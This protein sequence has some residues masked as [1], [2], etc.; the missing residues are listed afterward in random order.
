MIV[1]DNPQI[2]SADDNES[3][4]QIRIE[5]LVHLSRELAERVSLLENVGGC[6]EIKNGAVQEAE[7]CSAIVPKNRRISLGDVE[8]SP[9]LVAPRSPYEREE[10]A[11]IIAVVE[12]GPANNMFDR[13]LAIEQQLDEEERLSFENVVDVRPNCLPESTFSLLI[14]EDPCSISFAFGVLTVGLSI[15][16]LGL[17]LASSVSVDKNPLSIPTDVDRIVTVS[18]FTG[19]LVGC[20][21]ED[22][23]PQGLQLIANGARHVLLLNGKKKVHKQ[24]IVTSIL[25]LVVG[26]LFLASL[27][28]NIAQ[29]DDVIAIFYDVL[30]LEFVE[31]IDD[32]AFALAKRGF[33]GRSLLIATNTEN[34]LVISDNSQQAVLKRTSSKF[35]Q[36][37]RLSHAGMIASKSR[38]NYVARFIYFMNAVIIVAGLAFVTITQDNGSYRCETINVLFS[39]EIWEKANVI[40]EGSIKQQLLIYSYFNGLYRED[41]THHGYPKYVEQSKNDGAA[42]EDTVGAEIVWCDDINSWVFRHPHI[43]NGNDCSWLWKSPQNG[44][45]DVTSTDNADWSAWVGE[46]QGEIKP[47]THISI[48]CNECFTSSDCNYRG[49]CVNKRCICD[50][51]THFGDKCEFESACDNL[52]TEK[53]NNISNDGK[54]M[55]WEQKNPIERIQD[56]NVYNRPVYI[57]RGLSGQPWDFRL[58]KILKP[59]TSVPSTE[60]SFSPSPPTFPP[61]GEPTLAPTPKKSFDGNSGVEST[62]TN[63]PSQILKPPLPPP[64]PPSTYPTIDSLIDNYVQNEYD[65]NFDFADIDDFFGRTPLHNLDD[66]LEDYSVVISFTGSRFYGTIVP[67]D[68]TFQAL[69]PRDYHAFW[70]ESFDV[71]RTFIISDTT[72][73]STP[74]GADWYEMRRR[75]KT[76]RNPNVQ[77]KYG[78]YGAMINVME[79]E[80]TGFFHCVRST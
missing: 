36:E 34:K 62:D 79:Y 51:N 80:G 23:V 18:Q 10:S 9:S 6:Q 77:F 1:G 5:Q 25:R 72:F 66:I 29:N 59:E 65:E 58:F 37:Q 49:S 63:V 16:C 42:F 33:F 17:T 30:A 61:T 15:L 54:T 21:M 50:D 4:S 8:S 48:T 64:T 35:I 39:E 67:S 56:S 22:E 60:P 14:T 13:I 46:N 78:P 69:F 27:F 40:H 12:D 73:E 38:P 7:S 68:T 31:K 57:Q 2:E 11:V 71:N 75:V 47:L 55:F 32:T 76:V 43:I 24:I 74:V 44:N 45:Y 41:G 19:V 26:Y 3:H 28:I 52:A 53:T 70:Y 20:L